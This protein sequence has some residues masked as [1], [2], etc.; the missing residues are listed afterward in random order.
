MKSKHASPFFVR[1][2]ECIV[3]STPSNAVQ[4]REVRFTAS[5]ES[6]SSGIFTFIYAERGVV[7]AEPAG[8]NI[9]PQSS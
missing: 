1:R 9:R 4:G 3:L 6:T 8:N 2:V 5:V 7:A